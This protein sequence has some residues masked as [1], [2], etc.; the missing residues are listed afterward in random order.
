M[1]Q[2]IAIIGAGVI[3]VTTALELQRA[4]QTN[5]TIFTDKRPQDTTSTKAGAVFDPYRPGNMAEAEI[6]DITTLGLD[7]YNEI[8]RNHPESETGV[9]LH[10]HF[11]PGVK[12]QNLDGPFAKVMGD[13]RLLLS[14]DTKVPKG[15]H[16]TIHY[17]NV[18][19]IDPPVTLHWLVTK[20]MQDGGRM[21]KVPTITN[22]HEFIKNTPADIF[23]NCTGLGAGKL[24]DDREIKPMRGQI[25][26]LNRIPDFDYSYLTDDVLYVFPRTAT[27]MIICGGTTEEG[28]WDE[29]TTE[30]AVAR[31]LD[32][33]PRLVPSLGSLDEKDILRTYA[34][35]RPFRTSGPRIEKERVS[36]K[37]LVHNYGHGGSGWTFNWGSAEKTIDLAFS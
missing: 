23:F 4:G 32:N 17:K 2:E 24:A 25:V 10:D 8:V 6:I 19:F 7:R 31:I 9:R 22:L 27:G 15:Y 35:L 29:E 37:I 3:G 21:L 13:A 14:P 16:S 26:V 5:I 30:D 1:K 18:P 34:G 33:A 28:I 12:L 11:A 36:G 20:F